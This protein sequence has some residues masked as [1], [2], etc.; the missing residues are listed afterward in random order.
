M[1]SH[2]HH[3]VAGSKWKVYLPA[4]IS[5]IMLLVGLAADF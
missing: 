2:E 1:Q 3:H 4:I 5:M